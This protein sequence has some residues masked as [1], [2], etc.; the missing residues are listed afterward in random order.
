MMGAVGLCRRG[1]SGGSDGVR[2]LLRSRSRRLLAMI[3]NGS[4][5]GNSSGMIDAINKHC[6][7]HRR[8]FW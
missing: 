5:K 7:S 1:R 4:D 6:L 2:D 3:L 8:R